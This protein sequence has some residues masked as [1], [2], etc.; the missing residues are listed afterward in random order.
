MS[1]AFKKVHF[2]MERVVVFN[3]FLLNFL[4]NTENSIFLQTI[5][6]IALSEVSEIISF[7]SRSLP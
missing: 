4:A 3:W 6:I 7:E 5:S 1:A 2:D